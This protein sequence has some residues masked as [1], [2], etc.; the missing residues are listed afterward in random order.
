MGI[1]FILVRTKWGSPLNI[2]ERLPQTLKM[3][4]MRGG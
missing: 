3:C 1:V 2:E 4:Q